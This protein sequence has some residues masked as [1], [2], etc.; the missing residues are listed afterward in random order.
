MIVTWPASLPACQRTR[1]TRDDGVV[2]DKSDS[3]ATH[4]RSLYD[5]PYYDVQLSLEALDPA[6]QATLDAF[7]ASNRLNE[8]DVVIHPHT[9]RL[10]I[11]GPAVTS[12]VGSTHVT[13]V[14]PMRGVRL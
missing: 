5:Q 9:Y 6:E 1:V 8:L 10:K 11:V 2:T 3:G 14:L 4:L 13:V 7:L 12:W